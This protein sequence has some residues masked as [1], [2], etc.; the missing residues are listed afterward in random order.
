MVPKVTALRLGRGRAKRVQVY[1]DGRFALSLEA[2]TALRE[3]LNVGKELSSGDLEALARSDKFCRCHNAALRYLGYR[4]RS[5]FELKERLS[6]RGFESETIEAVLGRLKEQGLVDD[7]KFAQFWVDN[8]R[9]FS[10]RS[11]RLTGLELKRKRVADDLIEQ[12]S[13]SITDEESAYR[14]AQGRARRLPVSD[15]QGFRRRL[16]EYLKRR[17]FSYRVINNTVAQLWQEMRD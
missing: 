1:L 17:G 12:V 13:S 9:T 8:R 6:Q 15:Y 16:G 4:P 10:P 5:E 14:A 2:E 3:G 11:R 7:L